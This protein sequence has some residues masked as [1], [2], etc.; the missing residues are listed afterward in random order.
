[1]PGTMPRMS[2]SNWRRL[3]AAGHPDPDP[4]GL[5]G[6]C[7]DG[8]G[9]T[10]GSLDP[11]VLSGTGLGPEGREPAQPCGF[12]DLSVLSG[13]AP[14]AIASLWMAQLSSAPLTSAPTSTTRQ[15]SHSQ[16]STTTIEASAPYVLP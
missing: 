12:P 14:A 8:S 16:S 2:R 13:T 3:L 4:E 11:A 6:R 1:M 7:S 15:L 5:V 10:R 9:V